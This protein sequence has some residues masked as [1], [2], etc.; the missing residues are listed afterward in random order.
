[1]IT[2][3]LPDS[4]KK[5]LKD[6]S[7]IL[8]LANSISSGL[9]REA[10]AGKINNKLVDLS[11]K[12]KNG[13]KVEII[14]S[15]NKESLEILR[16]T[17]AHIFAQAITRLHPKALITIGPPIENGFYYDVDYEL[18]EENLPKIE[19]EMQKIVKE[20]LQINVEYKTKEEALKFFKNNKYKQ[21]IIEAITKGNLN[22]DEVH[23]GS[24]EENKFKFYK[25]GDFSDLCRGPHLP[26]T[27][28]IKAF[29]LDKITKAYWRGDSKN[30]QLSRVYGFVFWKKTELDEYYRI[31]EE[32][33]KRDHRVIG[34]QLGLFMT[35][36][37]APGMTFFLDKGYIIYRELQN[38]IR[39][40]YKKYEYKEVMT[41][42]MFNKKLWEISGHWEHYKED[43]FV[44]N[45]EGQEF[46]LKPMNCP[47]H[48]LI[49]KNEFRSY[50][51]LPLRIADFGALHRNE[52]SGTL[53]GLTR[54]RKFCQD[55]AHIF[56]SLQQVEKEIADLLEFVDYV[57]SNV[58]KIP[59]D[60]ELSTRPEDFLGTIELWDMA[61]KSLAQ[62]IKDSGKK[63]QI[64]KGDGAFYGPKIDFRLKDTLGRIWQTATIQLDFNLPQ[65]FELKF[66]TQSSGIEQPVM[67]HRAVL[68][69]I[70][71]FMGMIIE[72]FEGKFP[73]WLSPTQIKIMNV[74][75]RHIEYCENIKKQ[76]E[77]HNFRVSTDFSREG[78]GKKIAKSREEEKPNY[79][80]VLGDEN[81]K[82]KNISVRTRKIVNGKNE[83]YEIE[84][85]K[86]IENIF[87]ERKNKTIK[88]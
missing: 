23:E 64:C 81:V 68:G 10:I 3:E 28:M 16:H 24:L 53:S 58:F 74:A 66:E 76:L 39:E 29:K 26:R 65:R 55:D 56:C 80:L 44:L 5:E 72:H 62:A 70:E 71:R 59:Y 63:Y 85:D 21:E 83:Q 9:A 14:T 6:N 34:K 69:S 50:K 40:L 15:K 82:N 13:D 61:E 27:G 4:S 52:L 43:M 88:N 75:D 7:T 87:E 60:I 19:L 11:Q 54:V 32:A 41:P 30:K 37:F 51:E 48:C 45:V 17:T 20:N 33:K 47:S 35:H 36:E 38:F 49:F 2:I 12:L 42:N 1:M 78:V 86:F 8:D 18:S 67:I 84:I 79:T 77:E 46:S 57:Y 22:D 31:L 73:L 25:Q